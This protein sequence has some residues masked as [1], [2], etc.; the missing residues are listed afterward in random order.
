MDVVDI[1]TIAIG[2]ITVVLL[3]SLLIMVRTTYVLVPR[4]R[5]QPAE[6]TEENET[7]AG[8]Q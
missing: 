5:D 4:D 6:N 7:P 1:I 2:A 8:G 3:V